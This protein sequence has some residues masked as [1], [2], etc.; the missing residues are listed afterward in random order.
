[1]VDVLMDD[2]GGDRII[3]SSLSSPSLDPISDFRFEQRKERLV[4]LYL[5]TDADVGVRNAGV[6]VCCAW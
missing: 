5:P 4:L 1:M 6:V 3:L 2:D